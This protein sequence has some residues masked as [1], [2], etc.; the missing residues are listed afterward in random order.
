MKRI[1][2]STCV[3]C[4]ETIPTYLF[5]FEKIVDILEV[6]NIFIRPSYDKINDI[7]CLE[8]SETEILK[9]KRGSYIVL[10]DDKTKAVLTEAEY[11][12]KMRAQ[13]LNDC[14]LF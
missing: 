14:G 1:I 3:D 7:I 12:E 11:K 6:P 10:Y 8:I 2:K 13:H 9:I 4:T 5:N